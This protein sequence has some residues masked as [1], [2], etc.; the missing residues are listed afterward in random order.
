MT[1]VCFPNLKGKKKTLCCVV[2]EV[3]ETEGKRGQNVSEMGSRSRISWSL[4][5]V[6]SRFASEIGYRTVAR[7][8]VRGS[9][10]V[11]VVGLRQ[12]ILLHLL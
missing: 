8:M 6:A 11:R 9:D 4:G 2:L 5:C 12:G 10:W 7:R 3:E 1:L